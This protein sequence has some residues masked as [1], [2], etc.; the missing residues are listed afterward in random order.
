MYCGNCFRDNALVGALRQQGHAALMVPL[1]LPMTL[2]EADQSAGTPIFYSGINVYLD[3]KLPG[4]KHAP[5][6]VRQWLASPRLLRWAAG[7]AAKTRAADVGALTLSML[8]GESGR[9]AIELQ[10]LT[11][12]LQ[13]HVK[14]DVV[15]LSN[16]LLAGLI[17]SLKQSLACPVT[18]MLQGEDAFLDSLPTA[19]REAAWKLLTERVAEA[20]LLVAPSH[21]FGQLMQR[22][23]QLDPNRVKVVPNGINLEGFQPATTAPPVPTIGFFARM[24]PEKGLADVVAA[25]IELKQTNS[26][27]GLRLRIGGGCGPNDEPFVLQMQNRLREA[28]C[29]NEVDFLKN[30]SR[31]EK[32]AFLQSLSVFSTPA[33]YGEAFGLYLVE[34]WA[35]GLPVV[36]PAVAA[37]PELIAASGGGLLYQPTHP[38][39]LAEA[40][41]KLLLDVPLA[42]RLATQGRAA[43]AQKFSAAAMA[44]ALVKVWQEIKP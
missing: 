26:V 37:Y 41:E 42:R 38:H 6:F 24:C 2:D 4:F 23:L 14:P 5:A 44:T 27:P 35:C 9:Q 7:R 12:W 33:R 3:Q 20:D 22:R 43:A 40:L 10:E 1:Y 11:H 16:V 13:H 30:P 21:Y 39:A 8:R 32:I 25:F 29:L 18:A 19:Q 36:Q 31:T 34:A 15:C 28:G 17:R